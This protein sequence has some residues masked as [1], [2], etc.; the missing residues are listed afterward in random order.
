MRHSLLSILSLLYPLL[1]EKTNKEKLISDA[2]ELGKQTRNSY[3]SAV[4]K[5]SEIFDLIHYDV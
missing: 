3:R 1:Y 5:S 2:C 4:N